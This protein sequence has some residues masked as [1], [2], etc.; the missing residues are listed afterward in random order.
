[1]TD[2]KRLKK[3]V[4]LKHYTNTYESFD[5]VDLLKAIAKLNE[6]WLR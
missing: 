4:L 5:T 6:E 2:V 3:K 1:M